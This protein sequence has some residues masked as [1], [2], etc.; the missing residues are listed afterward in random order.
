MI[1][2]LVRGCSN[3]WIATSG[4]FGD[5]L[6]KLW[7]SN[8]FKCKG[9]VVFNGKLLTHNKDVTGYYPSNFDLNNKQFVYVDDSYF[10]GITAKKIDDYLQKTYSSIKSISVIYDGSKVKSKKVNSFFRY[11]DELEK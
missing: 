5:S 10:S 7:K 6:Y 3:E 8:K 1:L 4:E 11:Y 2:D 9:M